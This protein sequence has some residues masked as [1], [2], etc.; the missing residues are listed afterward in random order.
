MNISRR[1]FLYSTG[2][3]GL[4]ST[5]G[6]GCSSPQVVVVRQATPNPLIG[7]R[8]F[9]FEPVSWDGFTYD[10]QSEADWLAS[11][12]PKQVESFNEDKRNVTERMMKRFEAEAK[13]D[14]V[15]KLGSAGAGEFAIAMHIKAYERGM[16]QWSFAIKDESG[17]VVDEL[18]GPNR[19]GGWGFA[20][21]FTNLIV[22]AT[23]DILKYLRKRY[24][25]EGE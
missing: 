24:K 14:E 1:N 7:K 6:F 19:G 5:V 17:Q 23:V 16:F 11:R 15:I 2:A 13:S 10:G 20:I 8:T 21:Q 18:E 4:V 9:V 12:K 3:V 22:L 25:N